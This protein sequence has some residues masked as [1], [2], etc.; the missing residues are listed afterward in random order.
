MTS[1]ERTIKGVFWIAVAIEICILADAFINEVYT[2]HR[3]FNILL[4]F[5]IIAYTYSQIRK[6]H[7]EE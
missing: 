3:A 2:F 6:D 4:Y 7:D 1:R 5:A